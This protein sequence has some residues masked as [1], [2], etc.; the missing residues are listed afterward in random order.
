[1]HLHIEGLPCQKAGQQAHRGTGIAQIQRFFR[2]LE[3]V[4]ADPVNGHPSLQRPFD[5]HPHVTERLEG[6]Q[7]VLALQEATDFGH[8]L[9]QRAKHD[10]TV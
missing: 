5:L 2:C 4:Q 6:S 9:G 8:P 3:S 10:G 1:M 7:A